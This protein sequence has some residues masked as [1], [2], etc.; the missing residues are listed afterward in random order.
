LGS[1]LIIK[2][3]YIIRLRTHIWPLASG[4]LI[5]FSCLGLA[6]FSFGMILPNMQIDFDMNATQAGIV[7]SAN[8]L[9][10]F[11][12]LF[13]V[14]KF[15]VKFGVAKLIS[16]AL[17]TQAVGMILMAFAPH[18]IFVTLIFIIIGF[19]GALANIAVMTYIA[20]VVPPHIKGRATGI[21]VAGI[22]LSVIVSGTIVPFVEVFS[23]I[24][25]R[26][27]WSIFAFFIIFIVFFTYRTL[28]SFVPHAS[29]KQIHDSLLLKDIFSHIPFIKTGLL[30]FVFGATA[31]MYMTF[32]VV[33]A[34]TQWQVSTEISGIFWAILGITSIFSGPVF[35]MISDRIGRYSTLGILF[36]LQSVA[37]G[38]LAFNIPSIFLLVSAGI[39]GFSTWAVP[40]IM[41]TISSELFGPSHTARILSLVTIF[42]GMG[43]IIGP[44]AA[45]I[46]TD[47]TGDFGVI[48]GFSSIGLLF[49]CVFSFYYAKDKES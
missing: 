41:A 39:F 34:I 10:Y 21:V 2:K 13:I 22:G 14:S 6:R 40:S 7:G 30:Y 35:G 43:Q 20:Q 19:F 26:I 42:F 25:W 45:G 46:V 48:F 24:S 36:G 17:F 37:H 18:Y 27:S 23:P 5:V 31:I 29:N 44:L 15:Y 33:A 16:R 38:L 1:S 49:A 3:G 28:V 8:F 4:M 12:G 32:F 11:I 47:A 9:G